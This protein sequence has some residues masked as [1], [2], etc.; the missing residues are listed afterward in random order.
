MMNIHILFPEI[1][2]HTE[3]IPRHIVKV[4]N[5]PNWWPTEWLEWALV[6]MPEFE[7]NGALL[8]T[9][10]GHPASRAI[11]RW[12][13]NDVRERVTKAA[14]EAVVERIE[15]EGDLPDKAVQ[16]LRN[17]F[18]KSAKALSMSIGYVIFF[19]L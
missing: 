12:E 13:A 1:R 17:Q 10:L 18:G 11:G 15:R 2:G 7:L 14:I 19:E 16:L 6:L 4:F 9:V 8:R 5:L 3:V